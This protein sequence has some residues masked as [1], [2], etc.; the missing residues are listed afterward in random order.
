MKNNYITNIL[1]L[2]I[3]IGLLK[4]LIFPTSVT[5]NSQEYESIITKLDSIYKS[6]DSL[7]TIINNRLSELD[8]KET[9]IINNHATT[10]NAILS[11][12]MS[13]D[14]IALFIANQIRDRKQTLL[15]LQ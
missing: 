2:L 3:I 6:N 4:V 1:L 8:V 9:T 13:N 12:D 15:L 5:Y 14:D 10:K 7:L 11:G